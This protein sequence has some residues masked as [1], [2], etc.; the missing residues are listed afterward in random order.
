M[1]DNPNRLYKRIGILTDQ[2]EKLKVQLKQKDAKFNAARLKFLKDDTNLRS[3]IHLMTSP[4]DRAH[5]DVVK[6]TVNCYN[7]NDMEGIEPELA[8]FFNEKIKLMKDEAQLEV[9]KITQNVSHLYD[10]IEKY[11]AL[12]PKHFGLIDMELA[13]I[14]SGVAI[15]SPAA[16]PVWQAFMNA[17][18]RNHFSTIIKQVA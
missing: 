5:A 9:D 18:P 4:I 15:I 17:Y 12:K 11:K 1:L 6:L 13:E 2:I 10:K 3:A 8:E 16:F 14:F 7:F